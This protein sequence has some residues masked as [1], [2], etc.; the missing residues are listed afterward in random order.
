[1]SDASRQSRLLDAHVSG[2]GGTTR[3]I[4]DDTTLGAVHPAAFRFT[5]AHELGHYVLHHEPASVLSDSLVAAVGFVV[6]ALALRRLVRRWG[7]R[8]GVERQGDIAALPLFWGLYLLWGF[9]SA[10][11]SNA[12]ARRYERQADRYGLDLS[13]EPHGMAEFM[14]HDADTARLRPTPVEYA[15]FYTH[16]AD[17]ER[18]ATAMRWRATFAKVR[19]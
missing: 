8:C 15:L 9:A 7:P 12:I 11:V 2:L 6:V 1:V 19:R 3:I 16:P 4:V 14:I 17:A 13:Q 5:I 18:V 10:P